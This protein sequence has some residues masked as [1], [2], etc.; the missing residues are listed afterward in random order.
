[1][2]TQDRVAAFMDEHDI[3]GEPEY[4]LLDL[5]AEVCELAADACASTEYGTGDSDLEVARDEIGDAMFSL[6]S[7]ANALG[8]RRRR[9]PRR[10][11]GDVRRPDR[12]DG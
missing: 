8:R 12:G 5:A 2:Q 6:R 9:R 10:R 4:Q 3:D 7:F 11:R 1:M